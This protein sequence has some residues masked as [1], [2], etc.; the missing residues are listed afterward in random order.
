MFW[1]P[2]SKLMIFRI[3]SAGILPAN[4]DCAADSPTLNHC[5]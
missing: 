2:N 4:L 3:R 1:T 5:H